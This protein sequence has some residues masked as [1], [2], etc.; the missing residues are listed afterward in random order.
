[1]VVR[2]VNY[3]VVGNNVNSNIIHQWVGDIYTGKG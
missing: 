2:D 3:N 1:M